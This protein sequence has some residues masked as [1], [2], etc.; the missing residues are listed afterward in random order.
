MRIINKPMSVLSIQTSQARI[1]D[2]GDTQS[3]DVEP[4]VTVE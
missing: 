2:K 4:K 1:T 3:Y